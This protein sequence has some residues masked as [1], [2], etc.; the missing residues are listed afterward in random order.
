MVF[1]RVSTETCRQV[2]EAAVTVVKVRFDT[3][4]LDL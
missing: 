1:V 2:W 4:G 3:T